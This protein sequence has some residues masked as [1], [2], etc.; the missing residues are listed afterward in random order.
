M[1]CLKFS[2]SGEHGS[3]GCTIG[4]APHV[5]VGAYGTDPLDALHRASGIA[6]EMDAILKE[7][8][9]LALIPGVSQVAT[10][11]KAINGASDILK[12]GGDVSDIAKAIGPST[13]NALTSILRSFL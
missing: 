5:F 10:A 6:K 2:R 3:V 4:L 11:M 1:A 7:H 9:E 12:K 13:A 8:P